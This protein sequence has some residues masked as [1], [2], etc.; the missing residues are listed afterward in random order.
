MATGGL[1]YNQRTITIITANIG[2]A[3]KPYVKGDLDKCRVV[4]R[5]LVKRVRPSLVFLQESKFQDIARNY[6]FPKEYESAFKGEDRFLYDNTELELKMIDSGEI[7]TLRDRKFREFASYIA[8]EYINMAL[9]NTSKRTKNDSDILCV[10]WHGP[11]IEDGLN[12]KRRMVILKV[13]LLFVKA[14]GEKYDLPFI[15][16][17][18]FNLELAGAQIVLK[19]FDDMEVH[20]YHAER[21]PNRIDYFISSKSLTLIDV[22]IVPWNDT[23]SKRILNHDAIIGRLL[24]NS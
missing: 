19:S 6:Q 17:G 11:H 9:V 10:S 13:I 23:Q 20:D 8:P 18:D 14:V 5:K 24:M 22:Q 15:I 4:L 12:S 7:I 16:G 3:S 21:R 2:C 1:V